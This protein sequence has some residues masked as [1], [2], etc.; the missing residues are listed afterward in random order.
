MSRNILALFT[1]NKWKK[2]NILP[3]NLSIYLS[4]IKA[5][6]MPWQEFGIIN[7]HDFE[8]DPKRE[9]EKPNRR[10]GGSRHLSLKTYFSQKSL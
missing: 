5:V 2:K 3:I 7:F 4:E 1:S 10:K 9:K 8:K 6:T